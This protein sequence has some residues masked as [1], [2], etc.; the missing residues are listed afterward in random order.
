MR[1]AGSKVFNDIR[2]NACW[3]KYYTGLDIEKRKIIEDQLKGW[4]VIENGEREKIYY[5]T[6][7]KRVYLIWFD[8]N[9]KGITFGYL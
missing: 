4:K 1:S 7:D 3:Y 6:Q 9:G 8:E 5:K 2:N